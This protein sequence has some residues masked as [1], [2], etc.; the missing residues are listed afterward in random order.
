MNHEDP[1]VMTY[2]DGYATGTILI[3]NDAE[4]SRDEF[5]DKTN[6]H[7]T[8]IQENILNKAPDISQKEGESKPSRSRLIPTSTSIFPLRKSPSS[9]TRSTVSMSECK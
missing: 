7:F 9:S 4:V 5:D 6:I 3:P 2:E 1:F 8:F